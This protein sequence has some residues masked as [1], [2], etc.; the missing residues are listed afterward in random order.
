VTA[1]I[2]ERIT[3][4]RRLRFPAD[5]AASPAVTTRL[6]APATATN[7]F[8][9]A[10]RARS[11]RAVIAEVKMGSPTLGHIADRVDPLGLART[12][13]ANGAACLSVVVEPDFF[14]GSYELLRQCRLES[15]LPA[16]AKDFVVDERQV[17]AAHDAGASALLLVA[18]L[19][20]DGEELAGWG[21]A[22]RD[23]G[24]VPLVE[25]HDRTDLAKLGERPWELVGVNN[26]DLTTFR[27]GVETSVE[28]AGFLPKGCLAVSE[29]GIKSA[30]EIAQLADLGYHAFLIGES[31]LLAADPAAK[32]RE[33][34]A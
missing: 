32:L 10:I 33:L 25:T 1:G 30:A 16:I 22:V 5:G 6:S 11:G 23:R 3:A 28:L 4:Q 7:P 12:Y 26:R 15:G 31:L 18:S 2:L 19:Y 9:E 20:R 21:Q 17:D 8:L 24:L 27:V 29:S 14:F 34:L 13:A